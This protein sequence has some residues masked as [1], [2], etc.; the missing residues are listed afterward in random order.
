[1]NTNLFHNIAN[2]VMVA[3]AAATAALL[4]TGCTSLPDGTLDCSGSF[5]DARWTSIAIMA[6]GVLKVVVNISRD[7]L[8][9]LAKPQPPVQK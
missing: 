5:I 4:A 9:G 3:L 8:S 2:I 7:G 1:M 6:I